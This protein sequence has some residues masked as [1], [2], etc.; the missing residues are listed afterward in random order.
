MKYEEVYGFV[1][2]AKQG[3][4]TA[5]QSIM[6]ACLPMI[7]GN[8]NNLY[9]KNYDKADLIQVGYISVLNAVE[10][11]KLDSG[12]NFFCYA[13]TSIRQNYAALIRKAEKT[14]YEWSFNNKDG[15]GIE[16]IEF[17]EDSFDLQEDY[18]Q[19]EDRKHLVQALKKLEC[20]ELRIIEWFYFQKKSLREYCNLYDAN[21]NKVKREK[22]M[23][24]KKLFKI[25]ERK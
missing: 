10:K 12:V 25:I 19:R 5:Q 6:D 18:I 8:V 24:L 20:E 14:N 16:Y 21:Y 1:V 17:I 7:Y 11:Y 9:I 15:N 22:S 4:K 2:K 3:D 23:I 13:K